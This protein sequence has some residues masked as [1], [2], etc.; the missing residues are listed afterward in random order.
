MRRVLV[1][2]LAVGTGIALELTVQSLSGR[3][4]AW[5]SE[6]YWTLGLPVAALAALAVGFLAERRDWLAAGAIVPAQVTTM[7]ASSG[8]LVGGLALWPLTAGIASILGAP[9][10]VASFA[11]SR[12]R[13]LLVRDTMR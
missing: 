10:L 13:R 11:G 1:L 2:G 3:R 6:I 9:F 8:D 12:L 5:D 4:E 7:M